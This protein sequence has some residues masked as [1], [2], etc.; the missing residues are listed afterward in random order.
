M[1]AEDWLFII[2]LSVLICFCAVV[3]QIA[4]ETWPRDTSS[5]LITATDVSQGVTC[6]RFA[7]YDG[8]Q[9]FKTNTKH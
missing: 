8:I 1:K 3:Y 9:C 6:Y 4:V 7:H 5:Q 2:G